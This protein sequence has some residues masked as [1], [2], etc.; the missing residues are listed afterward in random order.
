MKHDEFV[1][2]VQHRAE[3]PTRGRAIRVT[4]AVLTTLGER[5]Q[6]GEASDLAAEL[7]LEI[8]WFI[9]DADSG[10]IFDYQHFIQR[11]A[12]RANAEYADA[13]YYAQVVVDVVSETTSENELDDVKDQLPEDYDDL[14]ELIGEDYYP[15]E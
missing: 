3:L 5:L 4:R 6:P 8:D 14:F 11:V 15:E 12:E 2:R 9:H 7:P 10:Q 13:N 1:G